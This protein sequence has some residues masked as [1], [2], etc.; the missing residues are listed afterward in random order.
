MMVNKIA[1]WTGLSLGALVLCVL[2]AYAAVSRMASEKL[3]RT[4]DAHGVDIP[5]PM[6]LTEEERAELRAEGQ[7]GAVDL[8]AIAL[9]R[10]IARGK[11]LVESRFICIEC[12]GAD[13]GGGVMVDDPAMG[14][15]LGPNLTSGA[16][17]ITTGYSMTD[18]D[19]IVRHG[20]RRDGRPAVMPSEDFVGMSDRELSDIVAYVRSRPPVDRAVPRST[21][22]PIGKLLLATGKWHLSVD[23][24]DDHHASHRR[25]PPETGETVEFG[26]HLARVCTGCHRENFEGGRI[27]QGPPSWA[28]AKN[29]TPHA[30]GLAGW[31]YEQF[32]AVMREG[33]LPDGSSVKEPM[34]LLTPY[35]KRMTQTELRA[36]FRYLTSL[37]PRPSGR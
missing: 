28:P 1:K 24:L 20:I 10:A 3:E 27:A 21:L 5:L 8:E 7:E 14:S 35:G 2:L 26:A 18:W 22:G 23:M 4:F 25:E 32:E 29:L 19:R 30:E 16:G 31:S 33:R 11:H 9:E 34:T 36:L 17:S 37:P 15:L 12:H 6:P 13:F